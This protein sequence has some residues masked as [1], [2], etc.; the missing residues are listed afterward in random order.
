MKRVILGVVFASLCAIGTIG[1]QTVVHGGYI[2][3]GRLDAST[4]TE[5][6]PVKTGTGTPP[7]TCNVGDLY[8]KSGTGSPAANFSVCD[9]ANTWTA[10]GPSG[11]APSPQYGLFSALPA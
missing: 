2:V 6:S 5:T 3:K 7:V 8:F 11:G 9:P 10:V 1:A 4:G